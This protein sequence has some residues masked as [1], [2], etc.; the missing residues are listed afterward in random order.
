MRFE[1]ITL[2]IA[3]IVE[4]DKPEV[5]LHFSRL[6]RDVRMTANEAERYAYEMI[7]AVNELRKREETNNPR[8][9]PVILDPQ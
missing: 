2:K 5:Q 6:V 9:D 8:I 1:E 7:D 3:P 4:S